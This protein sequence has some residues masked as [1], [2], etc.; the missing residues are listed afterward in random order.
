LLDF[1]LPGTLLQIDG[2]PALRASGAQIFVGHQS[3]HNLARHVGPQ[4]QV[5]SNRHRLAAQI[6]C[7]IQWLKQVHG[8]SVYDV[9]LPA[10]RGGLNYDPVSDASITQSKGVALA[11]LTA[12]CLPVM[13]ANR[14]GDCIAAA[15]AG[16]RGLLNGVLE[17]TLLAFSKRGVAASELIAYIGPAI[18]KMNFEVGDEVRDAFLNAAKPSEIANIS[19]FFIQQTSPG[20]WLCDLVGLA[21]MQ[22]EKHGVHLLPS[23]RTPTADCTYAN[24]SKYFSYRYFCHHP[25][26]AQGDGRQ[27]TLI[28]LPH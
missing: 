26:A 21:R 15:H 22:L 12:D 23:H 16:W 11:I 6:G 28:W 7:Q 8:T 17:Y 3:E 4:A 2:S 9:D 1:E 24:S 10:L 20:K 18:G 25:K 13:F 5:D 19:A 14:Q 27:V